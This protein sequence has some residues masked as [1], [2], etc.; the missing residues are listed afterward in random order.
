MIYEQHKLSVHFINI[1][2]FMLCEIS[3][4]DAE[5]QRCHMHHCVAEQIGSRYDAGAPRSSWSPPQLGE[6]E[7]WSNL[8]VILAAMKAATLVRCHVDCSPIFTSKWVHN[9]LRRHHLPVKNL[10]WSFSHFNW[11]TYWWRFCW[12]FQVKRE[13]V[14]KRPST[15]YL[16]GCVITDV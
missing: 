16:Y 2:W 3:A 9:I 11:T 8:T 14:F 4:V 12:Q 1:P 6:I 13:I 7:I 10:H 5:M 15:V